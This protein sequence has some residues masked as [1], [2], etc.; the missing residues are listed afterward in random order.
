MRVL[1]RKVDLAKRQ[2][3][4]ARSGGDRAAIV[5][6]GRDEVQWTF[7]EWEPIKPLTE[8]DGAIP[9]LTD[10]TTLAS[11]TEVKARRLNS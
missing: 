8:R 1:G 2:S 7:T 9:D 11:T 4:L 6:H 3:V 5:V 10:V